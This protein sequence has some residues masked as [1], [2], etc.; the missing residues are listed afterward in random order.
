MT[1]QKLLTDR[2]LLP[3]FQMD[4]KEGGVQLIAGGP[5]NKWEVIKSLFFSMIV[6]AKIRYGSP[7]RIL[8]LTRI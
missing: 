2:Y 5:D 8:F 1:G 6:S 3:H 4:D 7:L